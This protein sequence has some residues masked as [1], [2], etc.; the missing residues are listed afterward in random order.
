[1]D[2]FGMVFGLRAMLRIKLLRRELLGIG[3]IK[4]QYFNALG[5]DMSLKKLWEEDEAEKAAKR[6]R[7][8]KDLFT[9]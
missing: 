8:Q 5:M 9:L 4:R 7:K 6:E 2:T 3:K 1:M